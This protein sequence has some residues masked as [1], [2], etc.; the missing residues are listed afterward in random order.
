MF[1]DLKSNEPEPEQEAAMAVGMEEGAGRGVWGAGSVAMDLLRALPGVLPS[2][3]RGLAAEA[4]TLRG[5]AAMTQQEL[6][7]AMHR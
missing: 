5:L 7:A 3:A 4:G 1:K 6:E 2:N